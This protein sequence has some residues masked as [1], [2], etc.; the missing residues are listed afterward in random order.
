MRVSIDTLRVMPNDQIA[1]AERTMTAAAAKAPADPMTF[2]PYLRAAIGYWRLREEA[3]RVA[4]ES[5]AYLEATT[6]RILCEDQFRLLVGRSFHLKDDH[7][8]FSDAA[9]L[10][11]A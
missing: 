4:D 9:A 7:I 11:E 3:A 1:E 2:T 10:P 5:A 8:S 6:E